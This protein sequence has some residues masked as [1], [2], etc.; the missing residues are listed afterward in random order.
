[1]NAQ[2]PSTF[3]ALARALHWLMAV[4][5]VAMLFIG[6]AMVSSIAARPALIDLHRPLGIAILVLAILRLAYRLQHRPPALPADLPRWQVAAAHA[7]HVLLYALMLAMPLIGWAMLSAGGYPIVLSAGLQLPAIAPHDA[8]L[9]AWLRSAHGWLA[10]LLF[11]VVMAHLGA[12]LFHHWVRR[13]GVLRS[14][15]GTG[16]TPA[17]SHDAGDPSP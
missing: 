15:L 16:R 17:H 1:M 5:I 14:M 3:T 7:S 13:D 2:T 6:V 4:L 9:Y 10:Y 11:A 8:A 12:A